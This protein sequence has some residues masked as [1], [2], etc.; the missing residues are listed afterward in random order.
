M[1]EKTVVENSANLNSQNSLIEDLKNLGLKKGDVVLVHSSLSSIGWVCGGEISVIGA[2]LKV[3]GQ[4]GTLVMPAQTRE[5]SD[6]KDWCRPAVPKE[7]HEKIR[8]TMPAF[9]VI[10]TPIKGLGSIAEVFRTYRGT[11]RSNHPVVSFTANGKQSTEIIKKHDLSSMFG[12]D[13]PLGKLYELHAKILF[14]GTDYDTCTALHLAEDLSNYSK[15]FVNG[16]AM[17]ENGERV[18]KVVESIDYDS[19]DFEK[20]GLDFEKEHN[21]I[22]GKIGQS[23]SK[24]IDFKEIVDYGVQ[25]INNNR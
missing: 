20:I 15:L 23:H 5:N 3:I 10:N 11:K 13:S 8:A 24:I 6:P 21:V 25:W 12:M 16:F 19:E 1:S 2:L 22:I 7:W 9:D 4:D 17:I 14:L 18:W